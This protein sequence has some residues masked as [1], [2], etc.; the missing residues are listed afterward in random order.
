MAHF[1][2]CNFC[3]WVEESDPVA[4]AK[5]HAK[6]RSIDHAKEKHPELYA[7]SICEACG[8]QG[9]DTCV[10]ELRYLQEGRR[11][12]YIQSLWEKSAEAWAVDEA[13]RRLARG[14]FIT[15][16][17]LKRRLREARGKQDDSSGGRR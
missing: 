14:E 13:K 12:A 2:A 6:Q 3:P 11:E 5:G 17:E 7:M 15:A 10:K 16:D 1:A 9:C 8:G 4:Y